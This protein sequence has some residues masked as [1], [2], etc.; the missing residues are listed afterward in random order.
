VERLQDGAAGPGQPY[1]FGPFCLSPDQKSLTKDG[2]PVG[3]TPK[4][5]DTLAVLVSRHGQLVG[6][7]DLLREVW[8]DTFVEEANLAQ[9]VSVLRKALGDDPANPVYI[10]T[11]PK[12]GYR[13][14]APVTRFAPVAVATPDQPA[15]IPAASQPRSFRIAVWIGAA[16]LLLMLVLALVPLSRALDG[17]ARR[18]VIAVVPITSL[19][20]DGRDSLLAEALTEELVSQ[21]GRLAPKRVGV[22]GRTS[23]ARHRSEG[24]HLSDLGRDLGVGYVVEGSLRREGDRIRASVR[25]LSTADGALV[26]SDTL[27]LLPG[28]SLLAQV[29]LARAVTGQ[30]QMMLALDPVALP[31][32]PVTDNPRAYERFLEAEHQWRE[33]TK[34][35]FAG[36]KAVRM[37]EQAIALDPQ[38]ALAYARMADVLLNIPV[39]TNIDGY[40]AAQDAARKAIAIDDGLAEGHEALGVAAMHLFDWTTAERELTRTEELDPERRNVDFM[41]LRGRFDDAV[42]ES[43]R[44]IEADPLNM[45]AYHMAGVYS[46][47]ARRY[48]DAIGLLKKAMEM[49][50]KHVYARTRLAQAYSTISR[51]ADAIAVL[52]GSGIW[53]E[54]ERG[55][56]YGRMNRSQ[57]ALESL[58]ALDRHLPTGL[59]LGK[60]L[61][62]VGLGRHEHAF[63]W[64]NSACTQ[65]DY[66]LIYFTADSRFDVLRSDPRYD[67]VIQCIGFPKH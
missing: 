27:E 40:V 60:A 17:G 8:P 41:I 3:L 23:L 39:P 47:F 49:E 61:V 19:G 4:V 15:T 20:T 9:N 26:W 65:R 53:G 13:F 16:A 14:A 38:F 1:F 18:V 33:R 37:Y 28:D 45:L 36:P 6:K 57:E 30:V 24:R 2:E 59:A 67:K 52:E 63:F 50:P 42:A 58:A 66:Q 32:R 7:D 62:H 34:D 54:A 46:I 11:I 51:Y 5:F 31:A 10:E 25:L 22:L 21:L 55:Y 29:R 44:R 56:A 43:M 48:D 12:R 64:L 35:A